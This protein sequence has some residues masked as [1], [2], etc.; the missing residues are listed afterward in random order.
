MGNKMVIIFVGR[1]PSPAP[2]ARSV[3]ENKTVR[4]SSNGWRRDSRTSGTWIVGK[5]R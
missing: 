2:T 4:R 5:R 3:L 1:S